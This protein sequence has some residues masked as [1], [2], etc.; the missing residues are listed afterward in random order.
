MKETRMRSVLFLGNDDSVVELLERLEA[1]ID[2][3]VYDL[4]DLTTEERAVVEGYLDV[5]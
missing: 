2:D 3:A 4:F 5:F 1:E